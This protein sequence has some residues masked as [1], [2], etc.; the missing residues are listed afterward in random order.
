MGK[1]LDWEEREMNL[2]GYSPQ[3]VRSYQHAIK[4]LYTYYEKSPRDISDSEIKE[5]LLKKQATGCSGS[6][7]N[8]YVNAFNYVLQRLYKIGRKLDFRYSRKP[9][10]LPVVLSQEEI[11]KIFSH[12]KNKKHLL[13]LQLLYGSGLRVSEVVRLKARDLN[14]NE[15]TLMVREGKGKKDR[16]TVLSEKMTSPLKRFYYQ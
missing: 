2:T 13:I 1:F 11:S 6:T 10:T 12:V 14:C 8:I 3:T 7:I 4:E 15:K 9:K 16:L 5:F